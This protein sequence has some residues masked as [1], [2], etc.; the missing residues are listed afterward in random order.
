MRPTTYFN[1]DQP[2][3][4]SH[5][6]YG[7]RVRFY[8]SHNRTSTQ[9][10][11]K[12]KEK[13]KKKSGRSRK[14]MCA[15]IYIT[16]Y[17]SPYGGFFRFNHSPARVSRY[18]DKIIISHKEDSNT[19]TNT[20]CLYFCAPLQCGEKILNRRKVL[21]FHSVILREYSFFLGTLVHEL[22]VFMVQTNHY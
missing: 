6:S 12:Y 10:V 7:A 8:S 15:V 13:K 22:F 9:K 17:I 4:P 18:N 21:P 5:T 19:F 20:L 2:P 14:K 1:Q 11:N 3:A 16:A